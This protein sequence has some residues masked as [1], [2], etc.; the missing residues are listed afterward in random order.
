MDITSKKKD[1]IVRLICLILSFGLWLYITNVENP[2]KDYKLNKVP[3]QILNAD[4]LKEHKLVLAPNQ[5]F[6]VS[7]N[8]EGPA[9]DVYKITPD[10]FKINAN[11]AGYALKKGEN[12]VPVEIVNYPSNISIKNN[13]YLR[14]TII[15][16]EY[17]EKSVPVKSN[18]KIN[19]K[20]GY[21]AGEAQ[22]NPTTATVS[23]PSEYVN[24][25]KNLVV[26]GDIK[27]A[28]NNIT[29][30]VPLKPV[31]E[32]GKEVQ[33]VTIDPKSAE[34]TVPLSKGKLV[35]VNVP[36]QGNLPEGLVLKEIVPLESK[37]ELLGDESTLSSINTID[38]EPLDLSKINSS[39]EVNLPLKIPNNLKV[40]NNSKTV[41]VKVSVNKIITKDILKDIVASGLSEDLTAKLDPSKITVTVSGLEDD[42][43]NLKGDDISV[44]L[45]LANQ[46]EGTV[47]LRPN[48]ENKNNKIKIVKSNPESVNV[49]IEKKQQQQNP[50]EKQ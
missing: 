4:S 38:T 29:I 21:Y 30:N 24:K 23:G 45:D 44:T 5:S 42:I 14:V 35:A 34:V 33:Y 11:L 48:I 40:A 8:V 1:L 36:V 9:T 49:I 12:Q 15:L 18:V 26:D 31:D 17:I 6:Y 22:I 39:T 2:V 16:D 28:D 25:V 46:K 37:I 32:D 43:N 13:N 20:Q 3:V 47:S 19:T 41:K 10:Q 50:S 7:L 27:N